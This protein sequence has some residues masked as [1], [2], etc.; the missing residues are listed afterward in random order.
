MNGER[1][2]EPT[3]H[4]LEQAARLI[5]AYAQTL[6]RE[7]TICAHCS[8]ESFTNWDEHLEAGELQRMIVKLRKLSRA[9]LPRIEPLNPTIITGPARTIFRIRAEKGELT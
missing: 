9:G 6:S 5:G 2:R 1:E 3:L 7:S 4:P 8:R